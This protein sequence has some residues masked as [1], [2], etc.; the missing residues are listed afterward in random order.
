LVVIKG[1]TG[2]LGMVLAQA[3]DLIAGTGHLV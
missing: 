2:N 3:R 1:R